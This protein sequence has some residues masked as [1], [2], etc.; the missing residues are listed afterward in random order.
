MN[1]EDVIARLRRHEHDLRRRGVLHVG[2][3]GSVARNE[4]TPE[5]DLD[6]VIE[7]APEAAIDLFEYVGL[8]Q[9]LSDLFPTRV[10][11]ANLHRLKPMVRPSIERDA[12][13]AF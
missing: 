12:V 11:V 13:Y 9:Y 4:A 1:R 5:S 8:T 6:I 7:L 3:F 10:D 2:L